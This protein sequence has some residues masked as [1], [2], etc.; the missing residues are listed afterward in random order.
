MPSRSSK[1]AFRPCDDAR[2]SFREYV[3]ARKYDYGR[4]SA[5]ART[6]IAFARGDRAFPEISC[7]RELAASL[8]A[9]QV[10]GGL[11]EGARSAWRSFTAFRSRHPYSTRLGRCRA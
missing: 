10:G 5:A 11:L 6:F 1:Q 7:W 3:E 9:S 2:G 8:E 4:G